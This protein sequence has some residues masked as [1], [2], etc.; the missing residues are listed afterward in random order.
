MLQMLNMFAN[1][2]QPTPSVHDARMP[3]TLNMPEISPQPTPSVHDA[4]MQATLNMPEIS[5][6]PT[7]SVHDARMQ[8]TLNMPEISPQ[9]TPSV[10]DAEMQATLNMPEISPQPQPQPQPTPRPPKTGP[11]P[12][13]S[14]PEIL[15]QPQP[16]P[17]PTPRPPKT[18]PQPQPTPR[19]PSKPPHVILQGVHNNT[20]DGLAAKLSREACDLCLMRTQA[21]WRQFLVAVRD[22]GIVSISDS[23]IDQLGRQLHAHAA[24]PPQPAQSTTECLQRALRAVVLAGGVSGESLL[25]CQSKDERRAVKLRVVNGMVRTLARK[26]VLHHR[27]AEALGVWMFYLQLAA[28]VYNDHDC[29]EQVFC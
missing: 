14:L 13:P 23:Q 7:P 24:L 5:P 3:A 26:G 27:H 22:A 1:Q 2:P 10:H 21:A 15:P 16:Q 28:P 8:T 18:R 6:Q 25:V 20:L 4:G 19:T 11:Q 9:P 17:Q 29:A 12:T